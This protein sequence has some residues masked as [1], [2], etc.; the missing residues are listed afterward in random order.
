MRSPQ[1]RR[2][3][4]HQKMAI[5]LL[6]VVTLGVRRLVQPQADPLGVC[7]WRAWHPEGT[8]RGFAPDAAA[9]AP[10]RKNR[11]GVEPS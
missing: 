8:F 6:A 10:A 2:G 3:H 5:N 9:A 11:A 1:P 4:V 7:G